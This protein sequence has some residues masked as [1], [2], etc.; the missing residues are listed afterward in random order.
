LGVAPKKSLPPELV[1]AA[2]EEPLIIE[3]IS[4]VV[5]DSETEEAEE[6]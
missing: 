3:S 5:D 6:S 4:A 1:E 2:T